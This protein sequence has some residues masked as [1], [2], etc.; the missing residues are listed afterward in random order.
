MTMMSG[1]RGSTV[2]V[3]VGTEDV[4]WA[5]RGFWITPESRTVRRLAGAK[6]ARKN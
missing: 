6:P 1:V 3:A 2:G 5:P 4:V